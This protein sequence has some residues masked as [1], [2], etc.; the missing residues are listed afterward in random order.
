LKVTELTTENE[1][2]KRE[3]AELQD[4]LEAQVEK[5]SELEEKCS[6]QQELPTRRRQE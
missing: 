2:V 1:S 5:N 4:L 3:R 6:N